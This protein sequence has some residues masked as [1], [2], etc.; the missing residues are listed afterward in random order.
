MVGISGQ[1]PRL[2]IRGLL[3]VSNRPNKPQH[4]SVHPTIHQP[5]THTHTHASISHPHPSSTT[6]IHPRSPSTTQAYP[7][8]PSHPYPAHTQPIPAHRTRPF[9]IS[10]P[11]RHPLPHPTQCHPAP[12]ITPHRT[13]PHHI[14]HSTP[15]TTFYITHPLPSPTQPHL[16]APAPPITFSFVSSHQ[17]NWRLIRRAKCSNGAL[18]NHVYKGNLKDVQRRMGIKRIT[19]K[20]QKAPWYSPGPTSCSHPILDLFTCRW[21]A[22]NVMWDAL[23][24]L[25]WCCVTRARRLILRLKDSPG[26][27]WTF[28][29]SDEG[30]CCIS[31]PV[32]ERLHSTGFKYYE[33]DCGPSSEPS[34]LHIHDPDLWEGFSQETIRLSI[35]MYT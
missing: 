1:H 22:S 7:T 6:H 30:L 4:T 2:G 21:A 33:F 15:L 31:W 23:D 32:V 26:S 28:S 18:G 14:T 35:C 29:L 19:G 25:W 16:N 17:V 11:S 8:S 12:T 27:P 10:P 24:D 20:K 3:V 9:P 13:T 5:S 34:F